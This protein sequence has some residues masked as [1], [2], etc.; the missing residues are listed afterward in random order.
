MKATGASFHR[1]NSKQD[2]CTPKDFLYAVETRFGRIKFDLAA[3]Q[4]NHVAPFFFSETDN[5]LEYSW[6]ELGGLLFLNPPFGNIEPWAQKCHE[7][8]L[9]GAH[10]LFLTPASV[11]SEWF[12]NYVDDKAHVLFLRPRLSF[13]GINSYPKD[14]ILSFYC[15]SCSGYETWKWK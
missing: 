6:H 3:D 7:E 1:G 5:A 15:R 14:C 8:S 10:I 12:A 2:Y 4:K 11:G 9:N 13:D